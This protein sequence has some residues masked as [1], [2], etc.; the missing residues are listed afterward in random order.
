MGTVHRAFG[1]RFVVFPNDHLPPHVHVFGHGGEA[2]IE[3]SVTR[4]PVITWMV[5]IT[6]ADMRRI[7]AEVQEQHAVLL[8]AWRTING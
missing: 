4:K 7:F 2:K 8:D 5:G 3:L 6:R 1:F